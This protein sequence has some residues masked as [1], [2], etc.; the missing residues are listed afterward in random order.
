[1]TSEIANHNAVFESRDP[2]SANES[3]VS[4][5]RDWCNE[6]LLPAEKFSRPAVV[7]MAVLAV[8]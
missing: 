8:I 5:Q 6:G 2:G 7:E 4:S 3:A 1:M